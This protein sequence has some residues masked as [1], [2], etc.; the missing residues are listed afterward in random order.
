[1]SFCFQAII[2]MI[3]VMVRSN[4][5]KNDLEIMEEA[6]ASIFTNCIMRV[7]EENHARTMMCPGLSATMIL[8]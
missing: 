1:M 7:H 2:G 8:S 3:Y 4:G 5:M 6:H